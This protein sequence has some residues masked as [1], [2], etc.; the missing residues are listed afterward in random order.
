MNEVPLKCP[1]CKYKIVEAT[2]ERQL[3]EGQRNQYLSYV[4]MKE[5]A[6]DEKLSSC[7]FCT[8]FE[9]WPKANVGMDFMWCRKENCHKVTCAHCNVEC[10]PPTGG[11]YEEEQINQANNQ[12]QNSFMSHMECAELA[13]QREAVLAAIAKGNCF[14]NCHITTDI[15]SYLMF[16]CCREWNGLSVMWHHWAKGRKLH[17]HRKNIHA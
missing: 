1:T 14:S 4:A 12:A 6:A 10:A 9:I 5:I 3:D 16:L 2:F 17:S 13:P 11:G 8:Y 15:C 7:P